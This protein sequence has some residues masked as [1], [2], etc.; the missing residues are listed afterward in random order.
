[1]LQ[2][3]PPGPVRV[4]APPRL[5]A[6][7][8][9]HSAG[10]AAA[11]AVQQLGDRVQVL[12]HPAGRVDGADHLA[13]DVVQRL[14]ALRVVDPLGGRAVGLRDHHEARPAENRQRQADN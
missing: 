8:R 9:R 5:P 6:L 4:T 11:G 2:D 10:Q 7:G 3:E 1:M 12:K 13:V 14:G